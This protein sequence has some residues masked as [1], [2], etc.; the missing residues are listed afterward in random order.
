MRHLKRTAKL[1]RTSEHRNAMLAN[2]VCS[3][4]THRR[5]TTTLAKAKAARPV[6]EKMVTLGKKGTVH[7][8]RLAVAR[9]HQEDVAQVLFKEIA[10][11]FKDRN[12]GY[13]RIIKMNQRNGDAAQRAILEWVNEIAP[14][15]TAETPAAATETKPAET[16]SENPPKT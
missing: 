16:K 7:H 13:T 14:A 9:L 6:A 1:G 11:A 2:L 8:R 12:G 15:A 10:P 5:V 4:I 3:L